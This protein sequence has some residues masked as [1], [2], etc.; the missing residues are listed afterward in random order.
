MQTKVAIWGK[1]QF[2]L[3]IYLSRIIFN[4]NKKV[5]LVDSTRDKS[6]RAA[7]P[8]PSNIK[9]GVIDYRGVDFLLDDDTEVTKNYDVVLLNIDSYCEVVNDCN[10]VILVS[11]LFDFRIRDFN[12]SKL[13]INPILIVRDIIN[14]KVTNEYISNL[15]LPRIAAKCVYEIYNDSYDYKL[16]HDCYYN[17]V[18]KFTKLSKDFKEVLISLSEIILTEQRT[19][20]KSALKKAERGK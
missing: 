18:I 11:D 17:N 10:Q 12:E 20:I 9:S 4:C 14:Y 16:K 2:D 7:I 3:I 19:I 6:L 8:I 15:L 1:E 13:T 5:L